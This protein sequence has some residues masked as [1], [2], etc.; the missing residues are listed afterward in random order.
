MV[1]SEGRCGARQWEETGD[2][3]GTSEVETAGRLCSWDAGLR[4]RGQKAKDYASGRWV[5]GGRA[6][7]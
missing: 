6:I 5:E 2:L 3:G 1:G 4:G 7:F